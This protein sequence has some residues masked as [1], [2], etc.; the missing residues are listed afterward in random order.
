VGGIGR[1]PKLVFVGGGARSGKS[2]FALALARRFGRRRVLVATAEALDDE[3]RERIA[4]HRRERGDEF[5][6]I[7]E[8]RALCEALAGVAN[9]DVVVIDCVTLWI[10]NLLCAPSE[11]APAEVEAEVERLLDAVVSRPFVTI[12]VSNEVGM[13]IVPETPLG[14]AFRDVAGRAN[15]RLA[16]RASEVYLALFGTVVRLLPGPIE[17]FVES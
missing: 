9:A 4:R 3:M 7:E 6:T 1:S 8:P 12:A 11:A 16:A 15:Q 13:G 14:R 5:R 10:S 2:R 17:A